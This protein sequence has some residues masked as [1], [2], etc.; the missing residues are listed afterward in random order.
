MMTI[1]QYLDSLNRVVELLPSLRKDFEQMADEELRVEYQEQIQ[2][3]KDSLGEWFAYCET[4][5]H[6]EAIVL[7]EEQFRR[8]QVDLD[9]LGF[10]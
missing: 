6:R 5:E 10:Y 2:W 3:F 8:H 4:R 7:A 9:V 1:E